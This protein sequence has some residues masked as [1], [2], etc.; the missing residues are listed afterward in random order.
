[1][2]ILRNASGSGAGPVGTRTS[3][4]TRGRFAVLMV[5]AA[6]LGFVPAACAG[7]SAVSTNAASTGS[8]GVSPTTSA[9]ADCPKSEPYAVT[10]AA[11]WQSVFRVCLD[12]QSGSSASGV[13][14]GVLTNLS[15]AVLEIDPGAGDHSLHVDLPSV[16]KTASAAWLLLKGS[17]SPTNSGGVLVP[18]GASATAT[19]SAPFGANVGVD[20]VATGKDLLATSLI[21]LLQDKYPENKVVEKIPDV[22]DC[23]NSTTGLWSQFTGSNQ[24]S[25]SDVL[26]NV[27]AGYPACR[28]LV[29]Q[30]TGEPTV[31]PLPSGVA[32]QPSAGEPVPTDDGEVAPTDDSVQPT[33][34]GDLSDDG[35]GDGDAA[36]GDSADGVDAGGLDAASAGED[37][38]WSFLGDLGDLGD[39]VEFLPLL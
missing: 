33:D 12:F 19:S 31:P 7:A 39:L 20:L 3:K 1:M 11:K 36:G 37:S 16:T 32:E 35:D 24:P 34:D 22:R 29:K 15:G 30:A 28:S 5:G 9:S 2:H 18:P 21:N 25:W 27:V 4:S 8:N 6:V 17:V 38:S 13:H 14:E 23:V 26:N 10:L